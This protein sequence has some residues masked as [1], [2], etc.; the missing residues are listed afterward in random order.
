MREEERKKEER[1]EREEREL[2]LFIYII[3]WYSLYYFN[4]LYLKIEI[5]MLSEL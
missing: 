2:I 3:C 5:R 1:D 4:A